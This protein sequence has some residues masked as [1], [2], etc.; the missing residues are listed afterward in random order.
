MKLS[1]G[2]PKY[3]QIADVIGADVRTGKWD[4]GRMPSVRGIARQYSISIVTASRALQVLRDQGLIQ[5]VERSGAFRMPATTAERWAVLIRLTPGPLMAAVNTM[6]RQGFEALARRCPMHLHFDAFTFGP[7]LTNEAAIAAAKAAKA[8]EIRGLFMLPSRASDAEANAERVF[9]RGCRTVGLPVVLIE[10]ELRGQD[11]AREFDLVGLDDVGSAAE[12]TRHLMAMGCRRV[13]LV[14]ASPTSTHNDRVAGYLRVLHSSALAGRKKEMPSNV[15]WLPDEQP[16]EGVARHLA[17]RVLKDRL[18]GVI[19][20]HD[21]IA[22]GLI[23][24]LLRRG[25]HVPDEVKISGFD[26]IGAGPLLGIGL[27]SVANPVETIAEQAVRL[28]RLRIQEPGRIPVR[29][30]VPSPLIVRQSTDA[31]AHDTRKVP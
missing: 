15:I 4:G 12:S 21:Y 18:D 29:V 22:Y 7:S 31:R 6:T 20:Y 14:V 8:R 1:D 16:S 13:A 24:E 30:I 28:M 23:V 27:T 3:Q 25:V 9:L 10:R 5:L 2:A 17:D 11:T 26:N 19:C